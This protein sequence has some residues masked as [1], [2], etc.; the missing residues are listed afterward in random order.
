MR[1]V[2]LTF[3]DAVVSQYEN[4]APLL[5]GPRFGAASRLCSFNDPRRESGFSD[6][7]EGVGKTHDVK[8]VSDNGLHAG[9]DHL[10]AGSGHFL[11]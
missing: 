3:D 8:N 11:L 2:I 1:T 9:Q 6:E 7:R 5:K 10:T 4:V